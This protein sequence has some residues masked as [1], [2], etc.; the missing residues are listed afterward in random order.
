[1]MAG[2]L[3]QSNVN[4][5]D[6][7]VQMIENQRSYEV[8]ARLLSTAKDMDDGGASLMRLNQ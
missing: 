2:K 4:M 7:L 6:T 8:Q 3:E 5:T 1:V